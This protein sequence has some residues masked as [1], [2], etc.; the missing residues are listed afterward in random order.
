MS[1]SRTGWP[2]TGMR[3][4]LVGTGN[5]NDRREDGPQPTVEVADLTEL[6]ELLSRE[7]A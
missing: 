7:A 2:A 5:H 3:S 1:A 4:A 6:A